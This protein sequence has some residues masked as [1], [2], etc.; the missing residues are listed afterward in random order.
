MFTPWCGSYLGS[1]DVTGDVGGW[2][3]EIGRSRLRPTPVA[4][5]RSGEGGKG[6]AHRALGSHTDQQQQQKPSEVGSRP[7]RQATTTATIAYLVLL[8]A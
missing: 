7:I 4:V 5:C 2:L 8:S 3:G 1:A 6:P